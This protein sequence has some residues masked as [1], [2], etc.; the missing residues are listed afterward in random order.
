MNKTLINEVCVSS[1]SNLKVKKCWCAECVEFRTNTKRQDQDSF[2]LV[3]Q[4][5][6]SL[7]MAIVKL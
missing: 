3:K 4:N 1:D 7:K 5:D 6:G 2:Q